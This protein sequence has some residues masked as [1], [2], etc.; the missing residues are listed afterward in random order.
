LFYVDGVVRLGIREG[1]M[2]QRAWFDRWRRM[3]VGI[4]THTYTLSLTHL[5]GDVGLD[6]L[7]LLFLLLGLLV[8]DAG[9]EA[10]GQL[11]GIGRGLVGL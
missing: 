4:H 3:S 6:G 5:F 1:S 9:L 2:W 7:L 8:H 10:L 11:F